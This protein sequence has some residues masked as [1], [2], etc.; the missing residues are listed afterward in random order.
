MPKKKS[1]VT[2]FVELGLPFYSYPKEFIKN[3]FG[4]RWSDWYETYNGFHLTE[5]DSRFFFKLLT[6]LITVF[7]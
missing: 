2:L 4:C 3:I 7:S 6:N 1:Y 5:N